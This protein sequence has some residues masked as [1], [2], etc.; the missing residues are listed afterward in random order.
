MMGAPSAPYFL[1]VWGGYR[2]PLRLNA[3]ST[4]CATTPWRGE[5]RAEPVELRSREVSVSS[6]GQQRFF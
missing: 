4:L 6:L 1:L 2:L 5:G 3:P